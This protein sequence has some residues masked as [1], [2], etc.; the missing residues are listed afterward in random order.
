MK[1]DLEFT[2]KVQRASLL[3]SF[4]LACFHQQN[5]RQDLNNCNNVRAHICISQSVNEGYNYVF[6]QLVGNFFFSF[7]FCSLL[8]FVMIIL[9]P[10]FVMSACEPMISH[11]VIWLQCLLFELLVYQL[12]HSTKKSTFFVNWLVVHSS[13]CIEQ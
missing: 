1:H 4:P 3:G 5:V 9:P 6:M 10:M 8:Y 11:F 2:G 12:S 7:L 13:Y